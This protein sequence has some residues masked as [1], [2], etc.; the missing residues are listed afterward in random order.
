MR[1]LF[2]L[3]ALR[4]INHAK[5]IYSDIQAAYYTEPLTMLDFKNALKAIKPSQASAID[6]LFN[7]YGY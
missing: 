6:Q 5:N 1:L 2:L 4:F 3:I 7:S